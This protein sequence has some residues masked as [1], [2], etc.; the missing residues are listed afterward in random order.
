V[1]LV[2]IVGYKWRKP[3]PTHAISV[4]RG[5]GGFVE[6]VE[7]RRQ[8][9]CIAA[10]SAVRRGESHSGHSNNICGTVVWLL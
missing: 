10:W 9:I 2:Q 6:F 3:V 8:K 1:I 4:I 7:Y 5:I